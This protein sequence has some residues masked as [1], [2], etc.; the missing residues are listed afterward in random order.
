MAASRSSD[1]SSGTGIRPEDEGGTAADEDVDA[2]VDVDTDVDAVEE[3][4]GATVSAT[5]V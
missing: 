3:A 2:G 1:A 5:G 4:G